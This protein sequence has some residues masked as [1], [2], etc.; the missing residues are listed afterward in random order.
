MAVS[1]LLQTQKPTNLPKLMD[2]HGVGRAEYA[3]AA[4]VGMSTINHH[5]APGDATRPSP[6]LAIEY[7]SL[8]GLH[9]PALWCDPDEAQRLAEAALEEAPI[10]HRGEPSFRE[11]CADWRRE[12]LSASEKYQFLERR[13]GPPGPGSIARTGWKPAPTLRHMIEAVQDFSTPTSC[14]A[15]RRQRCSNSNRGPSRSG[16]SAI[17][18]SRLETMLLGDRP[19]LQHRDL[20]LCTGGRLDTKDTL[21]QASFALSF[22]PLP[23]SVRVGA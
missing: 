17:R 8:L 19:R 3:R 12:H 5:L 20:R 18:S 14:R 15:T 16:S 4:L 10:S 6:A 21:H 7:A 1:P 23:V 2:L 22:C 11:Q 9:A 13:P